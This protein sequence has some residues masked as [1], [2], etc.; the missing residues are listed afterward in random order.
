M[1]MED[2]PRPLNV[3]NAGQNRPFHARQSPCFRRTTEIL[4]PVR[5]QPH[6]LTA[7][8]PVQF[9]R[10]RHALDRVGRQDRVRIR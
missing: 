3:Q 1:R 6:V 2:D 8:V 9:R 10:Q 7:G 5:L 4:A